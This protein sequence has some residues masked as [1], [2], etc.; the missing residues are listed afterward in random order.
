[1]LIHP[2]GQFY[3]HARDYKTITA[4]PLAAAMGAEIRGADFAGMSDAQFTEIEDALFHHKMIYFRDVDLTHEQHETFSMRFGEWAEDAYTDGIPG[5]LN[6]QP[7]V[8][9]ADARGKHIFGSGWHSD[10][11][12]LVNPPAIA[13]LYGVE[14]PPYGGDTIWANTVLAYETLSDVM[15]DMLAPLRTH[16]SMKR[17][18]ESSMEYGEADD[19]PVGKL[20][21]LKGLGTNDLPEAV[22]RKVKGNFHPLIRTHPRSGEKSIYFDPSYTIGF[23]GMTPPEAEALMTF[24]TAHM[25]QPA[26]TCRL[27]W[28][29]KTLAVWDNR[30]SIHQ[31][32]NDYDGHRRELYRTTIA[33]EAPA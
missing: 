2:T 7:L 1:M 32:F 20:A 29:P 23:E 18:F 16:M 24:L 25:T 3:N 6:I 22:V 5:H 21:K 14:I 30:I 33:G 28:A 9:E 26:F 8:R 13:L 12:F 11:P 15:K 4:H 31:A 19:S 27:R 10:G 17:A